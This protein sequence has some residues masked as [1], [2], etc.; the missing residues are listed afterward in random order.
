MKRLFRA[1]LGAAIGVIPFA[2]SRAIPSNLDAGQIRAK[3]DAV[4]LDQPV[5]LTN[6]E[7]QLIMS[8]E[9]FY[10]MRRSG[11]ERAAWSGNTLDHRTGTYIC[12]ACGNPLYAAET[13]FD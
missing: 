2:C 11:T 3:L 9:Q 10:V 5:H 4:P 13:K 8:P 1:L 7:W 12:S 6:P